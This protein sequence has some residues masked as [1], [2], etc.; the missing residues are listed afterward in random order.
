[1][2]MSS[3][4]PGNIKSIAKDLV[5]IDYFRE[6]RNTR[7]D[8]YDFTSGW[9]HLRTWWFTVQKTDE[10]DA[11]KILDIWKVVKKHLKNAKENTLVIYNNFS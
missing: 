3:A 7:N 1:M 10:K 6:E 2:N 11:S 9:L 4:I 8:F 5:T